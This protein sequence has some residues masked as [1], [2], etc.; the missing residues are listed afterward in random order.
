MLVTCLTEKNFGYTLEEWQNAADTLGYETVSDMIYCLYEEE[1]WGV[2]S[3]SK[4]LGFSLDTNKMDALGVTRKTSGGANFIKNTKGIFR[5]LGPDKKERIF[6]SKS[7]KENKFSNVRCRHCG[8]VLITEWKENLDC[9]K[10]IKKHHCFGYIG[11]TNKCHCIDPK[12]VH[13]NKI[14]CKIANKHGY[15]TF[16]DLLYCEYVENKRVPEQIG[17]KIGIEANEIELNIRKCGIILWHKQIRK[18]VNISGRFRMIC[19]D[20]KRRNFRSRIVS[21]TQYK[22]LYCMHCKKELIRKI[23]CDEREAINKILKNHVCNLGHTSARVPKPFF[24][25]T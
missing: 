10:I 22:G 2:R 13:N 18:K 21:E 5:I 3:F 9:R 17:L 11:Y 4:K 25:G 6:I 15:E 12:I 14:L 19:V 1:G 16:S 8:K 7:I 20:G 23:N 24:S